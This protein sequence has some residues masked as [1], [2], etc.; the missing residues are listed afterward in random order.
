M[1]GI[2]TDTD[3]TSAYRALERLY[4]SYLTGLILTISSRA[5]ASSA[6]DVVFH[7]FRRQQQANF[8]PALK[9]LGLEHLPHAVAS[10]QYNYIVNRIGGV[11]V[12][13]VYENDQKAWIRYP[14][15]RWIWWGTAV[16]G[17][18]SEVSRAMLAGWHGNN[19][20]VLK[21]PRLGFVCTGQ[22]VDGQPGLEGYYKE[23]DRDLSPDELLAYSPGE[24][25]PRFRI[26]DAPK[27]PDVK[28]TEGKRQK[29]LRNYAATY[30]NAIVPVAVERLG[31][32]AGGHYAKAGA[33]LVGM[34]MHDEV[35]S[36]LGGIEPGPLGFAKA[37]VRLAT[38][39]GDDA[40]LEM[41][42]STAY[43]R[44]T[45]WRLMTGHENLSPEVFD[46]CNELWV[47]LALAHDRFIRFDVLERRDRGDAFWGWRI[48]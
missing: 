35:A 20:P 28:L 33:R 36:L 22:T 38:G 21:N 16:C 32:D 27:L 47:G 41:Q 6:A 39:Q 7:M 45:S 9:K 13:Y 14:P 23:Y 48:S 10:A 29:S 31:P 24:R 1:S 11:K 43:V 26:E 4:H 19:G 25:C 46:A 8:L 5:G 34:H 3:D 12:E 37:F 2:D 40:V 30:I 17:I 18:P 42:G 15:P 44:Q